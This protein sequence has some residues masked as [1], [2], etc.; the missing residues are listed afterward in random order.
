VIDRVPLLVGEAPARGTL[1]CFTVFSRS[2]RRLERLIGR[3]FEAVNLISRPLGPGERWPADQARASAALL[4]RDCLAGREVVLLGRRVSDAFRGL[5]PW[6]DSLAGSAW[7]SCGYPTVPDPR[8]GWSR[9]ILWIAP[10]PAGTSRWW[11]DRGNR[12]VARCFFRN[13]LGREEMPLAPAP[14]SLKGPEDFWP[15]ADTRSWPGLVP[16]RGNEGKE[17][18]AT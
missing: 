6:T 5:S 10:H 4:Y 7:F 14:P 18:T 16:D 8:G 11:N 2:G 15:L 13:V 1:G 3:P 12:S 17:T 9:C